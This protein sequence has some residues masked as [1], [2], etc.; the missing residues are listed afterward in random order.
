[1]PAPTLSVVIPVYNEEAG[2]PA[3]FD[4][5]Y[6]APAAMR[7]SS[8]SIFVTAARHVPSAFRK[9]GKIPGNNETDEG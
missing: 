7:T 5:L 9:S 1:M 8:V 4:R 2:L 6:A 3:L